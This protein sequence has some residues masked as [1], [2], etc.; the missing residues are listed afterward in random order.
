MHHMRNNIFHSSGNCLVPE[1]PKELE[2]KRLDNRVQ[3]LLRSFVDGLNPQERQ[4]MQELL[5]SKEGGIIL[6]K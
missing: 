5:Q 2:V 4:F 6:Q 1:T 3:K